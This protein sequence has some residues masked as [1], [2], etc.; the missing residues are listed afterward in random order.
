[1]APGAVFG[2]RLDWPKLAGKQMFFFSREIGLI[3]E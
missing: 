2:L 1:M 3:V